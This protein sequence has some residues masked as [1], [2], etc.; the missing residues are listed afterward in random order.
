MTAAYTIASGVLEG[1]AGVYY[2]VPDGAFA[3]RERVI[4]DA[5]KVVETAL[6]SFEAEIKRNH[7]TNPT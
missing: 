2:V 1:F 7:P 6:R 3:A 4:R 5:A